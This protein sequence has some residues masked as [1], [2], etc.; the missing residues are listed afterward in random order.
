MN[1]YSDIINLERPVSK[2]RRPMSI[3]NRA[4]QFAPF[5]ALSG[6]NEA[7][8]EASRI[9]Y[10]KKALSEGMKENINEK[11]KYIEKNLMFL[12]VINIICFVEDIKKDGGNYIKITGKVKK[13]YNNFIYMQNGEKIAFKDIFSIDG[14]DLDFITF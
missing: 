12:D 9:T 2:R 8:K 10:S 11:L 4:A 6:Y 3:E 7:V 5:S 13:I 1:D 14:N